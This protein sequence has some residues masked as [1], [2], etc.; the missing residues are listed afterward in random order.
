M[1][2]SESVTDQKLYKRVKR[3]AGDKFESKT[4][5]YKSAWIVREYKKRGGK[6]KRGSNKTSKK[7]GLKGWF[8]EKWIDLNRPIRNRQGKVIGYEACGRSNKKQAYPLCRP[9]HRISRSTPRTYKEISKRSINKAKKQKSKVK[10]SKN[11]K[12]N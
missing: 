2:L 7:S 8:K 10:G 11:I 6:F 4:G 5:I 9:S 3:A 1:K 12:F